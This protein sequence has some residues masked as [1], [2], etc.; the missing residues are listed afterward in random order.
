VRLRG[1]DELL[2]VNNCERSHYGAGGIRE[3]RVPEFERR[4][5]EETRAET[6]VWCVSFVSRKIERSCWTA[7]VLSPE[8]WEATGPS[9]RRKMPTR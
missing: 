5:E 7:E 8:E 1:D 6:A 9:E 4:D 2:V 3:A